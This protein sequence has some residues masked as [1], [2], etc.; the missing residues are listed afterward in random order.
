M[1]LTPSRQFEKIFRPSEYGETWSDVPHSEE[2]HK[3]IDEGNMT[4][5]D[6]VE[7]VK[8]SGVQVPVSVH[9]GYVVDGHHRVAAAIESNTP[10]RWEVSPSE[11]YEGQIP[12]GK[13]NG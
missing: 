13:K 8:K 4:H 6:M 5:A 7:S 10:V 2:F 12:K 11:M 9:K 3:V 1:P